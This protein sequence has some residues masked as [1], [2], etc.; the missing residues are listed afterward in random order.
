MA[1]RALVTQL[2][3][4]RCELPL[5]FAIRGYDGRS[6]DTGIREGLPTNGSL[7]KTFGANGIFVL[8][9]SFGFYAALAIQPDG[10]ILLRTSAGGV[11]SE[12]G[13]VNHHWASRCLI[14]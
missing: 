12:N 6:G 11:D 8:P 3:Y 1:V 4:A 9:G 7:D 14:W 10:K 2:P 13:P 5:T